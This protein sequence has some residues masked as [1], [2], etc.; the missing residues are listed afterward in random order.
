MINPD[1]ELIESLREQVTHPPAPPPGWEDDLI[2]RIS[3][4]PAR[5]SMAK[6]WSARSRQAQRR[7]RPLVAEL[8]AALAIA[9]VVVITGNRSRRLLVDPNVGHAGAAHD[10]ARVDI[11]RGAIEQNA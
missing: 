10:R 4:T 8:G 7:W 3:E 9:A 11:G 1:D 6:W 2:R 5:S